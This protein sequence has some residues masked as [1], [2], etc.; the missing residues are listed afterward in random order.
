MPPPTTNGHAHNGNA[1]Q[2]RMQNIHRPANAR[3]RPY[4]ERRSSAFPEALFLFQVA[5]ES[6]TLVHRSPVTIVESTCS[7]QPPE[8]VIKRLYDLVLVFLPVLKKRCSFATVDSRL[9]PSNPSPLR[10]ICS[11]ASPPHEYSRFSFV[12]PL[13]TNLRTSQTSYCTHTPSRTLDHCPLVETHDFS[14]TLDTFHTPQITPWPI[15]QPI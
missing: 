11:Y 10:P 5:S 12:I 13:H 9:S 7:T 3:S 14:S 1:H 4:G 8:P 15:H 6:V 2:R